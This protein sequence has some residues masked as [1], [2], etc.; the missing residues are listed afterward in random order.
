[1]HTFS[2]RMGSLTL[3][4]VGVGPAVMAQ[5]ATTGAIQVTVTDASGK[6]VEGTTVRLASGQI[7]RTLVTGPDGRVSFGLLNPGA[8]Q[9]GASRSGMTAPVQTLLL[10]VGETK[11]IGMKLAKEATAT[12]EVVAS[13]TSID[14]TA[15]STGSSFSLDKIDTV[16]KGRDMSTM[17]LLTPGVTSGGFASGNSGGSGGLDISINGASGAENSYSVDGLKTND[18]RYGGRGLSLVSDFIDQ[19]DIQT[20]GFKPESSALGGVFNAITK[21]G[22]NATAGSSW[23]NFTPESLKPGPKQNKFT[24]EDPSSTEYD[25]GAWLGGAFVKDIFFYSVGVN[26]TQRTVP[27]TSNLGG[28][29]VSK[30]EFPAVQYFAKFNWYLR[31]EHQLSLSMF[32]TNGTDKHPTSAPSASQADG[33]GTANFGLNTDNSTSSFSL[34]YD[35][36]LTSSLSLSLKAGQFKI[37]TKQ[38]PLDDSNPLVLDT[39]WYSPAGPGNVPALDGLIYARGGFGLNTAES[40][41]TNQL[42]GDLTWVIGSHTLKAGFSNLNSE[43]DLEEHY[44]G[45][46]RFTVDTRGGEARLRERII[47]NNSVVKADYV[48]F[49]LQDSWEIQ[50][51]LT[52][53][54]GARAE[55]QTQKDAL[56][57]TFLKFN[58]SDYIQPRIGFTWDVAGDGKSKLYGSYGRYYEQIPQRMAI[59]EF[60]KEIF[61]ENRYSE[62]YG[63]SHFVYDPTASNRVGTYSGTPTVVNYGASF[64]FPPVAEGLKLPQ[65]DEIQVGY[66]QT[67]GAWTPG[68]DFRYRKLTHPIEDSVITDAAG[69]NISADGI[70]ILWNPRPGSVAWTQGPASPDAGTRYA[71]ANSLFPE[72][73]NKY[74]AADLTLSYKTDVT[75]LNFSYTWSRLEGN[76][77]GLVSSSNGQPDANITASWDYYPYV[78]TGL[79]PLD[80]THQ[81]KVFGQRRFAFGKSVLTLGFNFLWQSGTPNSWFDDGSTST[82]PLP[83]IGSYG[84]AIPKNGKIGDQGRTPSDS[85]LDLSGNYDMAVGRFHIA[86]LVQITNVLNSRKTAT[87][88]NTYTDGGGVPL[89]AGQFGSAVTWNPGRT[90]RFG[91]KVRF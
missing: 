52:V 75:F 59:R 29:A 1:M 36:S 13:G 28:D 70:A 82:P 16:P 86:P 4:L 84:N 21:S 23:V 63:D 61:I 3:M 83:D 22:N 89:P 49:Y 68:I 26:Y 78:G 79:L 30:F 10:S 17:A 62:S 41:T 42:T 66:Q 46:R 67:F 88:V 54:F 9:V 80:R 69:N 56:G 60:S 33:R 35:G 38:H 45:G 81:V 77:E 24:R 11:S 87:V 14:Q 71:P 12:V 47:S 58:M 39:L 27:A 53:F 18:M 64:Q 55:S 37:D 74:T 85:S 73:F 31:P 8:W 57:R 40:N 7:A 34:A 91:L 15:T 90:C 25:L 76:Y 65:R 44:S 72:A 50:R 43:Y 51:G 32:G 6:P 5:S 19:V 48:G 2:R 20:G